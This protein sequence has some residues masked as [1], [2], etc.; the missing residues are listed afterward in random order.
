MVYKIKVWDGD[1]MIFEGYSKRVPKTGEDFLNI[2]FS[3]AKKGTTV[4]FYDFSQEKEFPEYSIEKVK[5][6][7]D[8]AKLKYRLLNSTKCGAYSPYVYRVC[9]DFQI[10]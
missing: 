10:I 5:K 2:A 4:H 7:C 9:T 1:A 3:V 8:Q 6:A